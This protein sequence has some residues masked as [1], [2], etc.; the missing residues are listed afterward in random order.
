[1]KDQIG[2]NRVRV[3][4][5]ILFLVIFGLIR[6]PLSGRLDTWMAFQ[7]GSPS[8]AWADFIVYTM[9]ALLGL[10]VGLVILGG[11]FRVGKPWLISGCVI[12]LYHYLNVIAGALFVAGKI[13]FNVDIFNIIY[14][15][16]GGQRL[17]GVCTYML[18]ILGGA[19]IARGLCDPDR[20]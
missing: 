12:L 16:Y 5:G 11:C 8:G 15:G 2:R 17:G 1:M 20:K 9:Y 6:S 13:D 10:S 14:A 3:I 7:L 4:G 19:L 18:L